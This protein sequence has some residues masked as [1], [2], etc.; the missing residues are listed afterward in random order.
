MLL[1]DLQAFAAVIECASLTKAAVRL[2]LTQSAVSRRIQNLEQSLGI[3]LFVRTQRPPVPT[4]MALRIYEEAVQLLGGA[5]R[6]RRI[7]QETATPTGRFRVGFTQMVADIVVVNT[8]MSIKLAFPA[9]TMQVTTQWSSELEK[10]L[11]AGEIDI[12]T[13]LLAPSSQLPPGFVGEHVE[14]LDILVV[15]SKRCP[16]VGPTSIEELSH[17]GWILNPK[18][19][20]YRAALE[21]AM[22]GQGTTLKLAV[23]THDA[24]I[25]MR[26]VAAGLGLGLLPRRLLESSSLRSQLSIVEVSDF[27]LQMNIWVVS[28]LHPGNLKQA[29]ELLKLDIAE[30]FRST[31]QKTRP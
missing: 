22:G 2:R 31:H 8:V 20:G 4:L 24:T 1:E 30:G 18:G 25:Q 16:A 27:S 7:P 11:I 15:Q 5:E 17:H 6:L 3:L 21:S 19:C 9:L 14:T 10:L 13:L 23:D 28:P 29:N 12:A 26:M